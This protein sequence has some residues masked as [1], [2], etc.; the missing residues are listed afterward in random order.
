ML[1]NVQLNSTLM[2]FAVKTQAQLD[3]VLV[4]V[5]Q[6]AMLA[7]DPTGARERLSLPQD[8]ALWV[9][10][11]GNGEYRPYIRGLIITFR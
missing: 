3:S 6:T 7:I 8:R 9:W 1:A 10:L 5:P 2:M 11:S 4:A